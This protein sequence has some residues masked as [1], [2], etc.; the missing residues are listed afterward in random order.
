MLFLSPKNRSRRFVSSANHSLFSFNFLRTLQDNSNFH[1]NDIYR[2]LHDNVDFLRTILDSI[3]SNTTVLF[4]LF[5]TILSLLYTGGFAFINLLVSLLVFI[6]L[7]FYLLSSSDEPIYQPTEWINNL[8]A[9][10][11]TGLGQAVN[12]AVT[13][14]FIA[15]LKIA[16][17]YG[18]YTYVLHTLLGSNLVFL[19]TVIAAICAVTLK[20]YWAA[21]PGCL[22]L[23][24]VQERPFSALILLLAQIVPV[25][26]VDAA[27]YSE[28][29]G[30]GHQVKLPEE[31]MR[32]SGQMT[33]TQVLL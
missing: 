6:T 26:V 24:L 30:G 29:K 22:D 17:F 15:S 23:W 11:G 13:S 19:P 32:N 18:L 25:Y 16:A 8:L 5:S 1:L 2:L 31:S 28:V 7:L 14:V 9:M 4:T 27:I 33:V 12:D 21:L 3:W 20:S 10:G